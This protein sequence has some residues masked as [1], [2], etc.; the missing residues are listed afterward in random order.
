M[1]RIGID[2]TGGDN[3]SGIIVPAIKNFLG[4]NKEH[5]KFEM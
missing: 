2:C 1:I 4:K 3:G 5:S